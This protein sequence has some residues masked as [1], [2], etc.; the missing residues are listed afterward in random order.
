MHLD[1]PLALL[2]VQSLFDRWPRSLVPDLANSAVLAGGPKETPYFYGGPGLQ[3]VIEE[4]DGAT[5][6]VAAAFVY[7]DGIDEPRI[8]Y[9]DPDGNGELDDFY[10]VS[11]DLGNVF[12]LVD[13]TGA[14]IDRYQYG[15]FGQP[16]DPVTLAPIAG[17]PSAVG[18]PYLFTG[19][20]HDP[21]TG[22]YWYRT[23]LRPGGGKVH[24]AGH[25]RPVG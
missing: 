4:R 20:R 5:G 10:F 17:D 7:G 18:N 14:T 16:V 24:L 21:E 15:D 12:A 9:A 2:R 25:D 22:L 11:D 23:L 8:M 1:A 3:R 19:R 6:E 13:H